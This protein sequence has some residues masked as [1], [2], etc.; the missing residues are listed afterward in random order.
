M[1]SFVMLCVL[2]AVGHLLRSK[3]RI[4]HKLYLP[5]CVIGGVVGI[6]LKANRKRV[7]LGA[8]PSASVPGRRPAGD[9][10][11][12]SEYINCHTVFPVCSVQVL[13]VAWQR[14]RVS[15]VAR[16]WNRT[17]RCDFATLR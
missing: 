8:K 17:V 3:V 7:K 11:P 12:H 5:S 9:R 13:A 14:R 4:L 2:L 10:Q 15:S 1:L 16:C 6:K